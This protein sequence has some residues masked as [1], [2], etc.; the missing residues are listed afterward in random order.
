MPRD[1]HPPSTVEVAV[2]GESRGHAVLLIPW[3]ACGM[4]LDTGVGSQGGDL[5]VVWWNILFEHRTPDRLVSI[6]S[7]SSSH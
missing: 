3:T 4:G 7:C 6:E 5:H 1:P 2:C